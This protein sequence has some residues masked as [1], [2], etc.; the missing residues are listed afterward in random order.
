VFRGSALLFLCFPPASSLL[1]SQKYKQNYRA[2]KIQKAGRNRP[3][4]QKNSIKI[5]RIGIRR[6]CFCFEFKTNSKR[7]KACKIVEKKLEKIQEYQKHRKGNE[8]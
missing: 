8:K 4:E 3:K 1:F 6:I 2:F 7:K 5:N